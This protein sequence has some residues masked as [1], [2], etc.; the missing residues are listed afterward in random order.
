MGWQF[1][2]GGVEMN[3]GKAELLS[4][5]LF[6]SGCI[7]DHLTTAYG[8]TLPTVTEMNKIVLPLIGYGVWHIIEILI[9]V[10]GTCSGFI[11]VRLKS[12]LTRNLS[13]IALTMVG[14]I[15][16]YAGTQNLTIIFKILTS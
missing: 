4:M 15:R 1:D 2:V 14:L 7:F 16:L 8:L 11:A 9:I 5:M 12:N 3:I 6:A 13:M 10:A